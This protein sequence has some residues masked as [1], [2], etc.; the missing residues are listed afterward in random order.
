[1]RVMFLCVWMSAAT[2]GLGAEPGPV[3]PFRGVQ[4]RQKVFEFTEKPRL[5]KEGA[6][7]IVTFASKGKCDATAAVVDKDGK[8]VRHLASGVLGENAPWPFKQG[9]LSQAVEWDGKDDLGNA[10]PESCQVRVS[11]G[12]KARYAGDMLFEPYRPPPEGVVAMCCDSQGRL[13]LFGKTVVR[14]YSRQGEYLKTLMPHPANLAKGSVTASMN[15][16]SGEMV[17]SP[18]YVPSAECF[19]FP[20]QSGNGT[21]SKMHIWSLG[22]NGALKRPTLKPTQGYRTAAWGHAALS[23]DRGTLYLGFGAKCT[24]ICHAVYM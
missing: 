10:A 13:Y 9:S 4:T 20:L 18:V 3:N 16:V 7:W 19:I 1:M 2:V 5:K 21:H 15:I 11:L 14:N 12:L 6:K 22:T 17:S 8:I 23:P 24:G